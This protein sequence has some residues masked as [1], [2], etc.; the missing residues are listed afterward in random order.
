MG[1]DVRFV[2]DKERVGNWYRFSKGAYTEFA[3]YDIYG[4]SCNVDMVVVH[5][6]EAQRRNENLRAGVGGRSNKAVGWLGRMRA[7]SSLSFKF[8]VLWRDL[9]MRWVCHSLGAAG[10]CHLLH[11]SQPLG[12]GR[13]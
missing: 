12:A 7:R 5:S 9:M 6:I 1:W 13:G 10:D 4:S 8:V 3:G 2:G 11:L